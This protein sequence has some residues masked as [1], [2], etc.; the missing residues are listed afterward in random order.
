MN[1]SSSSMTEPRKPA[2]S[3]AALEFVKQANADRPVGESAVDELPLRADA[4]PEARG[5][6]ANPKSKTR[7]PAPVLKQTTYQPFSTR[8]RSDL[9]RRLKRLSFHREEQE[10]EIKSVQHFVEE[11][12]IQWLDSQDEPQP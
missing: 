9:K 4:K 5:M 6:N 3:S 2:R 7:S 8:I 10:A 11:A 1:K 12:I